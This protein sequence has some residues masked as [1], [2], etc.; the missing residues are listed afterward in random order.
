MAYTT[1]ALVRA[2]TGMTDAS[3]I[4]DATVQAKID[5]AANVIDSKIYSVYKLPL[6]GTSNFIDLLCLEIAASL[7]YMDEYGEETENL[8]KGWKKRL[9]FAMAQLDDI[10]KVKSV[11]VD[12]SGHELDRNS[13]R[14][15]V[16]YPDDASS[17]PSAVDSTA[18]KLT[19]DQTF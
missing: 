3:K 10:Q 18:P 4:S 8:D 19:M 15:P 2:A 13:I 12:T 11:L 17:D 14:Q 7:L 16:G 6:S 9:D 1:V 5:F